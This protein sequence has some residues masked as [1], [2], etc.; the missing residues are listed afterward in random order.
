MREQPPE[1]VVLTE[2]EPIL[3][4]RREQPVGL[5]HPARHQV[6]HQD[7]D[8]RLVPAQLQR[9]GIKR[10]LGR[11]DSCED[12]LPGRLLVPR[13][14]VHLASQEQPP[15]CPALE[16]RGELRRGEVVVLDGVPRLR[17]L[18]LLQARDRPEQLEL[19]LG[20]QAGRDA[21]HVQLVRLQALRLQEHLMPLRLGELHDLV[22]DRRAVPRSPRADRP[23]VQRRFRQVPLDDLPYRRP[24]PREPAGLPRKSVGPLV[25]REPVRLRLAV[26]P[27]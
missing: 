11:V 3:R 14:P 12:P 25:K 17:H 23:A 2:Q 19:D 10:G 27:L 20:R 7:T 24:R 15:D 6:V 26:L 8:H 13:R 5:I 1:R 21:V 22:L 18:H 9:L 16:A 4:S